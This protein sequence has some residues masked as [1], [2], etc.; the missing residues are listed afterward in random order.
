[1]G[2][3]G[4]RRKAKSGN[5]KEI[6]TEVLPCNDIRTLPKETPKLAHKRS[7]STDFTESPQEISPS[8]ISPASNRTRSLERYG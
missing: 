8:V 6:P 2:H 7:R 1:M 4:G 3:K 5:T